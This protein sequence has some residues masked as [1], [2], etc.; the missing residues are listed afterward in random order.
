MEQT[1]SRHAGNT[2]L[3]FP[4]MAL[5]ILSRTAGGIIML[6]QLYLKDLHATPLVISLL[7][8]FVWMGSLIGSTVWGTLADRY[9]RKRLLLLILMSSAVAT[10]S[11]ALLLPLAGVLPAVFLRVLM[12]TGLAPVTMA[13]VSAASTIDHRGRDLSYLSASRSTGSAL[14]KVIAGFLLAGL[15]YRLSFF[16]LALLPIVACFFLLFLPRAEKLGTK[17]RQSLSTSLRT[18][19]MNGLYISGTL[20]QMGTSGAASLIFV[21][22]ATLGIPVGIMGTINAIGAT[23]SILGMLVFGHLS[24]LV[25]RKVIFA[26]GFGISALA[27]LI[28]AFSRGGWGIALGYFVLGM[29]FSSL[30]AGSTSYIG[31]RTPMERQG[32]MFG[33]FNSSRGIGGVIGPLIAGALTPVVGFRS[34]LLVMAGIAF[35]GFL[36]VLGRTERGNGGHT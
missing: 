28:F 29:S 20:R 25:G 30:Y 36:T 14:G 10:G 15:G 22:M 34:M 27:P 31:D 9:S 11:L 8:S 26:F 23:T 6:A 1:S 12:V 5:S 7:T 3:I 35:L 16:S 33:L 13:I 32:T 18:G 24:D 19:G 4:L 17:K 21:Y 2:R